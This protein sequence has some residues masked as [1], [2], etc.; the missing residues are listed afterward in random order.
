[1]AN[2]TL[3][4]LFQDIA[5]E[6][7]NKRSDLTSTN[8]LVAA[9]F[10][11]EIA[12]II[13]DPSGTST[14][15]ASDILKGKTACISG[16]GTFT[17]GTMPNNGTTGTTLTT[18]GSSYTIPAGY[19]SGGTVKA[20]INNATIT[21]GAGTTTFSD[22]AYSSANSNYTVTASTSIAPPTVGTAGYISSTAGTKNSNSASKSLTL[23]KIGLT[24]T[25]TLSGKT[26]TPVIVRTAKASNATWVD[27][28][29][30][31][32]VSSPSEGAPY[33]QVDAAAVST[34]V[35]ANAST[36]VSSA[37]YGDD[38]NVSAATGS[39]TVNVGSNAA[40][41]LYVPIT[42][43]SASVS[44]D[45]VS[46]GTGWITGGSKTVA[47]GSVTSGTGRITVNSP[48]YN[49]TNSNFSISA[50][51]SIPAPTV[52]S[53][54]Y[55]SSSRGTK[56]SNSAIGSL[57]LNKVAIKTTL[58]NGGATTPVISRTTKPA[59][60]T[61]VDAASGA[62]TTT[63]PTSSA[64]VRVDVPASTKTITATP[65]VS[66]AGYGT[67]DYYTSSNGTTTGGHNAASSLYIPIKVGTVKSP[68]TTATISEPSY[69]STNANFTVS[70]SGTI[71]APTV[72]SEGYISSSVGTRSTGSINGSKA[73]NKIAIK[74]TG[75]SSSTTASIVAASKSSS[76][77][78]TN[79]AKSSP[80]T[81]VPTTTEPYVKIT[82]EKK[83][84]SVSATATVTSEGYGTKDQ[85]TATSASGSATVNA[86]TYYVP[87]KT[88]TITNTTSAS[89]ASPPSLNGSASKDSNKCLYLPLSLRVSS[90]SALTPSSSA[91]WV[92]SFP[93]G[94]G[95]NTLTTDITITTAQLKTADSN[96]KAE[97][98]L[99]GV[100]IFGVT[101]SIKTIDLQ[102]TENTFTQ[103]NNFSAASTVSNSSTTG[104]ITISNGGLVAAS[105]IKGTKVY[106]AVWNDLA[107]LIPVNEECE[108]EF[109][110]CYCFD[111]E[112]YY[113][114]DKYLDDG[115]IGI[116]SD[117]A[118]FE[119]GHKDGHK[120]L[121]CS[122]AG[123]VL[124]Y[125][126]KEYPVGTLLTCTKDGY[127]TEI[128]KEDKINY[129]E[130]IVGSYWKNE[131]EEYW[132]SE[133]RKVLVNRRKWIKVR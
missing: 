58:S 52:K 130:K 121:K 96:L 110:K 45:T 43:T 48:V 13:T 53:A 88:A 91:G 99:D 19:T 15:T 1:M 126:D 116:H 7:R 35:T 131:T 20:N 77:T 107:D 14:A 98:I 133:Q 4:E 59:D 125:V 115:I 11:E 104:T 40:S 132:G 73:L 9:N 81:T 89:V 112:K 86:A 29:S 93:S 108:L 38:V 26:V 109:G 83:T 8:K 100:D 94:T 41:T 84:L 10:P 30:G 127:L 118:G 47:A 113:K 69:N 111:G 44:G 123:F 74:A 129:P 25:V 37:G 56:T 87:I 72:G 128:K 50:S 62:G 22:P 57:T 66:T 117:V 79:A 36:V 114:S 61:W 18:Q 51:L 65:S 28:A 85:Y 5:N 67:T 55:I 24:N 71:A 2:P 82:A 97:N 70:A 103:V 92:S 122:V 27:A 21:S 76:D 6:I 39:K 33:V 3:A 63:K 42:T 68:N 54:G 31:V 106:N 17:T 16:D 78:Y 120:E 75:G 119:M 34:T 105:G 12:K 46:Y 124:A 90:S 49:S 95:S 102:T 64:Y 32:G 101:G 23:N 60:D 80:T